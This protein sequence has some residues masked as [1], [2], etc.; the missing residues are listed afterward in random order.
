[1]KG[2]TLMHFPY[3]LTLPSLS[4]LVL[5]ALIVIAICVISVIP[6][7]LLLIGEKK[8]VKRIKLKTAQQLW[9]IALTDVI[10]LINL[11]SISVPMNTLLGNSLLIL[12]LLDFALLALPLISALAMYFCAKWFV[13]LNHDQSLFFALSLLIATWAVTMLMP[14][15]LLLIVAGM[16][17]IF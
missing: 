13:K 4:P 7:I 15:L 8:N 5:A 1:M 6:I 14:R 12:E 16:S 3:Q 17:G 9:I 11:L 2:T 10:I